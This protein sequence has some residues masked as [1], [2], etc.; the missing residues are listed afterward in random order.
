ML[1]IN[2]KNLF[3][4]KYS[5]NEERK[6]RHKGKTKRIRTV[7]FIAFAIPLMLI[8]TLGTSAYQITSKA[9]VSKYEESTDSTMATM[10][11]YLN[12][13]FD[14]VK[15]RMAELVINENLNEYYN[16]Y[17]KE[18]TLQSRDYYN[19]ARDNFIALKSSLVYISDYSVFGEIGEAITSHDKTLPKSLYEDFKD[20]DE[21]K[22]FTESGNRK[23]WIGRHPYLD[24][25]TVSS[26]DRYAFSY[27]VKLQKNN[28]FI[29]IDIDKNFMEEVLNTMTFGNNSIKALVT[30]DGRIIAVQEKHHE[31]GK[32]DSKSWEPNND[33]STA[34]QSTLDA[35]EIGSTS[36]T[37]QGEKWLLEY[38]PIGST[39]IMLYSLI[40]S[41]VIMKDVNQVRNLTVIV[42]IF[43]LIIVGVIGIKLSSDI[44]NELLTTCNSLTTVSQGDLRVEFK[45]KRKD[46]FHMLN[47]SMNDMISN[48]RNLISGMKMFTDRVKNSAEGVV[49]VTSQVH[50]TMNNVSKSVDG[51]LEGVIIQAGDTEQCANKMS[52]LS[53]SLNA[54]Y[55]NSQQM[56]ETA[57]KTLQT[58][59]T[60]QI[61][62][63][64]LNN[65]TQD[66]VSVTENLISEIM[67]VQKKTDNI[68]EIIQYIN[69]IADNTNLLSLNASIEAARA[70]EYGRGF[71]V[72][73]EEIR[74]L[75]DQSKQFSNQI[76]IIIEDIGNVIKKTVTSAE[77]TGEHMLVQVSS[78]ED[79]NK[80][81][82]SIND[83]VSS[84]VGSLKLMQ[85]S[86]TEMILSKEN[87]LDDICNISSVSEESAAV[88]QESGDMIKKQLMSIALLT[89]EA[90]RLKV[91]VKK[92][93]ES[94]CHFVIE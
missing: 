72:V 22:V 91:E 89:D 69:N 65:K 66:T 31:D 82:N 61:M 58:I 13:V 44:S 20:K 5:K 94:M 1:K 42:I 4:K 90:D 92:L 8:I 24:S 74:K 46:E 60:G 63:E 54:I 34:I 80:V 93:E 67:Q 6:A 36:I 87:I 23:A 86:M 53:N 18:F 25:I 12:S 19:S 51:I 71:A 68:R 9:M 48:I 70:G 81:F 11:L 26:D 85:G 7:L 77:K 10:T 37:Y 39:G 49:E 79:T 55:E 32:I 21:A 50:N 76:S 64:E 84:L 28:G 15:S 35:K 47:I 29:V 17:G 38:S 30:G 41:D 14:N 16:R 73:A 59:S 75:A 52:D 43:G 33:F 40:P 56:N 45:T 57:D 27:V 88:S 2:T 62:V 3:S 83:Q 78:L